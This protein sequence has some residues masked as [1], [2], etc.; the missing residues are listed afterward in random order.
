MK[1]MLAVLLFG[2]LVGASF[3]VSCAVD[4]YR[5]TCASCPFDANGKVDRSC[6]DGYKQ[7]GIACTSAA[8]PI[9]STKYAAGK[10]PQVDACAEQLQ[11]CVA[12]VS[13]GDDRADCQEGSVMACYSAADSCTKRAALACGEIEKE[14]GP[15]TGMLLAVLALAGF[16]YFRKN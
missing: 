5:K 12:Q 6:S 13:T 16:A 3:A 1:R 10:C 14:C 15:P 9:M 4:A 8:Y 2:F 7:S 11:S